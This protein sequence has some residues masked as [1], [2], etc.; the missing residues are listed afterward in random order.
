MNR[1]TSLT[2]AEKKFLYDAVSEAERVS[3]K[4]LSWPH[5]NIVLHQAREQIASQRYASQRSAEREQERH[6]AEFTWNKPKPFRR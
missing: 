5:K 6:S 1:L 4:K 3:G 2:P